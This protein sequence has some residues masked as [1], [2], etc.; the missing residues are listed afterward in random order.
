LNKVETNSL[1]SV[2]YAVKVIP[3]WKEGSFIENDVLEE[4]KGTS[5]RYLNWFRFCFNWFYYRNIF[6]WNVFWIC[7]L[8]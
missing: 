4:I 5:F 6:H 2:I 8:T 1:S 7:P 3:L